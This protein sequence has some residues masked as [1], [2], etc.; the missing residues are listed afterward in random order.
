VGFRQSFS[1]VIAAVGVVAS[2]LTFIAVS[3]AS[4]VT[5]P[6]CTITASTNGQ[7][8][9]GT[10]GNDVIC[11]TGSTIT[12]NAGA[13][14][15]TVVVTGANDV[16]NGQDGVDTIDAS[17][18]STVT[19]NG[20]TGND[21]LIGSPT[22]DTLNGNTGTD[23]ITAGAG[24]DVVNTDPTEIATVTMGDGDD[25][26]NGG[27]AADSTVDGGAGN[28]SIT[29][30]PGDDDLT[31]GVGDDVIYGISGNDAEDGGDGVD[32]LNGGTG[33]DTLIGGAGNDTIS[34]G[35]G[36]D[37]LQ[38]SAG[39]DTITGDAGNDVIDG[40]EGTDALSGGVGDDTL[41]GGSGNDTLSGGDGLDNLQGGAGNDNIYGDSSSGADN[42][43][44]GA[45]TLSGGT[46]DDTLIGGSGNDTLSGG[47][48]NDA[49]EGGAGSDF[50]YGEG[51][52][53]SLTGGEGDDVLAGGAGIDLI[54]GGGGL[55]TCDYSAGESKTSTCTYD[56]SAPTLI[57]FVFGQASLD[58]NQPNPKINLD[59]QVVDTT[60]VDYL[61]LVCAISTPSGYVYRALDVTYSS[62]SGEFSNNID[63]TRLIGL[64]AYG[65]SRDLRV[66]GDIDVRKGQYPGQYSCT[67]EA[68]DLA[69]N[70]SST[71]AAARLK[72]TREASG[73]DDTAPVISSV[74]FT[75]NPV[76]S[77]PAAD[78]TTLS[79]T[80]SDETA[81]KWGYFQCEVWSGGANN[82][83][84]ELGWTDGSVFDY[85]SAARST[86]QI[87]DSKSKRYSI[88][89]TIAKGSPP[90]D[91]KCNFYSDDILDNKI[92]V[93]NV[94]TFTVQR[95]GSVF[96]DSPP[97]LTVTSDVNVVDVGSQQQ[98][99]RVKLHQT[100]VSGSRWSYF[101]CG[102][103]G[104][105]GR[106]FNVGYAYGQ[107]V[108]D[109]TTMHTLK[110]FQESGNA[111][112]FVEDIVFTVPFGYTPGKY[113][114]DATILDTLGNRS[115]P[116][117]LL[118]FTVNRTPAG[119]PSAPTSF[120]FTSYKPTT[121]RLNWSA[122]L[123]DGD[124]SITSYVT[125]F[126][127]N[128]TTWQDIPNG[129]GPSLSLV[130]DNLR[131][132]SDYW[133]R[134]RGENGGT[135]GQDVSFMTLNWTSIQAHTPPATVADAPN[136]FALNSVTSSSA[137]LSWAWNGYDGGS[138]I[139]NFTVETSR[140]SGTNWVLVPHSVSTSVN[141]GLSGLAPGTTY[142]VRVAAIN[143]VGHSDY[144]TGS[145]T[146]LTTAATAPQSVAVSNLS[147]TSLTLSWALPSSDG[148]SG[149][150]DYRVEVSGDGGSSW[151]AIAHDPSNGL[152]FI[153]SN[154]AKGRTYKFRVSAVTSFGVGAVSGVVS[155]TTGTTVASAPLNLTQSSLTSSSVV[156][157]WDRPADNGGSGLTDYSVETSRDSGTNWVL[158][159][160]SVSTS[161][162]LGL[163]G[164]APG[165]TYQ[166][167]VAAINSVGRSDYLTG[168]LTTLAVPASAPQSLVSS[169]VTK[170]SLTL[171]WGL[172]VSNGGA[173]ITDYKVE[174]SSNGGTSWTAIPHTASN[175]LSF[176]VTG[177]TRAVAYQ[178]RVSAVTSGGAGAVSN[179]VSVTT[180]A[181]VPSAPSN[182]TFSSVTASGMTLAWSVPTDNGGS[183]LTDYV[184]ETSKDGSTWT[185]VPHTASTALGLTLTGLSPGTAY[186]VRVSAKN[187]IG[188]S[189]GYAT[190]SKTTLM[191]AAT[192]PT[193]LASSAVTSTSL[194][195]SWV[196]PSSNGGAPISDYKVEVSSNS[197]STWTAIPHTAS[198]ALSLNVTGLTRATAYQFRVSA[199]TGF[200]SGVLSSVFSVSTPAQTPSVPGTVTSS[201]ITNTGFSL[202]W[203]LPTDNGGAA[204]TDYTV[205]YSTDGTTWTPV[206]HTAS[207]SRSMAL[208]GLKGFTAYQVRVAAKNTSGNGTFTTPITVT[209]TGAVPGAPTALST[210]SV[211]ASSLTLSWTAPTAVAGMTVTDYL[212]EMSSNGGTTWTPVTHTASASTSMA[213]TGLTRATAYKF[214]VSAINAKGTGT[215]SAVSTVSTLALVPAAPTGLT[216]ATGY[217]TT[218]SVKFSWTAPTDNGGSA[219]TDYKIEY[220]TNGTTWTTLTHAASTATTATIT[221]L[222]TKTSY[223]IRVSTK[224]TIG[225]STP[226]TNLTTAT[227]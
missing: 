100:D 208:S 211:T 23:T 65:T 62:G 83:V 28:D 178:F 124:P 151:T 175:A 81:P 80:I 6:A 189:A 111:K 225:Y 118:A 31:G 48:S 43:N 55:N 108:H 207:T 220:S 138:A 12:V 168:S 176:N 22:A 187:A 58:V 11:V 73:F 78:A 17:G 180:L 206:T 227:H 213:F 20:G 222:T 137:G 15:D 173:A 56:V 72:V 116:Y 49:L 125:Q 99:I 139:T 201:A 66:A 50:I 190:G 144:L 215:A 146:T 216:V 36:T 107:G 60:G 76:D 123:I 27:T 223:Q 42:S 98:E 2:S 153:V 26:F 64:S 185:V 38:G 52:A 221:G 161:V 113:T 109:Y 126:S 39:D 47:D 196:I 191:T 53:D 170:S 92:W 120:S 159:P 134:I 157:G 219:I 41:I 105:P 199:V 188:V 183:A 25:T 133:F 152:S 142:Q 122:P 44:D 217:P 19:E 79:F 102:K 129:S 112:D 131:P 114:C 224:N 214:R 155:A 8:V 34:G 46:G 149:I 106:F 163:S 204:I 127:T 75:K 156:L 195:L 186:Q 169:S 32:Q 86:V 14:N 145:L 30:T 136:S 84:I 226:S 61:D 97:T 3:P 24:N 119:Q 63:G 198:N 174:V 193:G 51:G 115:D 37:N 148:G 171:S 200:G 121:G 177:L 45:D 154:L 77:G 7:T 197:G 87:L 104:G 59:F 182:L 103:V 150:S 160:H 209:T 212:I 143:S 218:T 35:D 74:S 202:A 162:N 70:K 205:Q 130:L 166:V 95:S 94:A 9:T 110:S 141:L 158:V 82:R 203:G 40:G 167:R 88:H 69:M 117:S 172:P 71:A 181:D 140:D 135:A 57:S 147:T 132:D 90:G 192:A 4:A 54:S 89:L 33:D 18:G 5:Y 93:Y 85:K 194:T 96:D 165:T 21:S 91:Y 210:S 164:L 128:G 16:I 101:E 67:L 68:Q 10:A 179:V 29:G 13:G 184:V 1:A